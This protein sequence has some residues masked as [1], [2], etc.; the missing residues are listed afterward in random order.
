MVLWV[1]AGT[2]LPLLYE[3]KSGDNV[4][5]YAP[6][7]NTTSATLHTNRESTVQLLKYIPETSEVIGSTF[8]KTELAKDTRSVTAPLQLQTASRKV[9]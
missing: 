9:F 5:D 7:L 1:A 4:T 6:I 2:P 3:P 8:S